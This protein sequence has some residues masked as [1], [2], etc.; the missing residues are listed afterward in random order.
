MVSA[1]PEQPRQGQPEGAEGEKPLRNK[2]SGIVQHPG[3][4]GEHTA[5]HSPAQT[6]WEREGAAGYTELFSLFSG[7][8]LLFSSAELFVTLRAELK[9]YTQLDVFFPLVS[10]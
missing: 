2:C 4:R 3:A 8:Q 6:A 9:S 10:C 1:S 7:F 5:V